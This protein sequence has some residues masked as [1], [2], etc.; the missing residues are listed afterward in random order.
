MRADIVAAFATVTTTAKRTNYPG[1]PAPAVNQRW[2]DKAPDL[3][4][5]EVVIL[6]LLTTVE[7]QWA[8]KSRATK[9]VTVTR[10]QCRVYRNGVDQ[11][12]TTKINVERMI[13]TARGMQYVGE[14]PPPQMPGSEGSK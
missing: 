12:R 2:A 3:A 6:V 13:P 11:K 8:P 4:G 1:N 10:A 5:R 7:S 14:G 9:K